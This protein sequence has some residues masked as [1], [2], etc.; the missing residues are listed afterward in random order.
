LELDPAK[1][2]GPQHCL[3]FTDCRLFTRPSEYEAEILPTVSRSHNSPI[4][5]PRQHH[6]EIP[7]PISLH[8]KSANTPLDGSESSWGGVGAQQSHL[9]AKSALTNNSCC[10]PTNQHA[11]IMTRMSRI[12]E[13]SVRQ[14]ALD[15][16]P[17]TEGTGN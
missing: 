15:M 3:V 7:S 5:I 11:D 2:S 16:M 8:K 9:A 10:L 6:A 12:I 13:E 4:A 1:L 14:D 17:T